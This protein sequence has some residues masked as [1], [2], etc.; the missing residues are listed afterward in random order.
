MGPK[1]RLT[2][3]ERNCVRISTRI[4]DVWGTLVPRSREYLEDSIALPDHLEMVRAKRSGFRK[5]PRIADANVNDNIR[6]F[7]DEIDVEML[8]GARPRWKAAMLILV[9]AQS[10]LS[11][12]PMV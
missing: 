5:R 8:V 11:L 10:Y 6:D 2:L 7:R 9:V 3:Q 4:L 1:R 12:A